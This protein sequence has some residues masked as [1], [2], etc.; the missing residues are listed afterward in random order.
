MANEPNPNGN[1]PNNTP[2]TAALEAKIKELESENGKLRK[3]V[4][5]ASADASKHKHEKEELKK[6][7]DARMTEDEKAK[8]AQADATA[9]MQQRIVELEA[10][11]RTATLASIGFDAETADTFAKAFSENNFDGLVEGIRKFIDAHDK[12]LKDQNIQN[13]PT[14]KSNGNSTVAK[15]RDEILAIKDPTER[16]QAIAD[17]IELFTT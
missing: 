3:S 8:A 12:A 6:Q 14:I 1:E 13:N 9:A 5:E 17:N 2:D 4:T 11:E 15:T 16:Q 7:L 10:K